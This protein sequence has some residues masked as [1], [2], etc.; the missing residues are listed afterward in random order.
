MLG[1]TKG[2]AKDRDQI[3]NSVII[4]SQVCVSKGH[5]LS[6]H[7]PVKLLIYQRGRAKFRTQATM[8][9]FSTKRP[10]KNVFSL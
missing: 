4:W 7:S 10:Q 3:I 1:I 9:T 8:I 5:G 6:T 2:L